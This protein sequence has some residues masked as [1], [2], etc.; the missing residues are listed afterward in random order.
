[1]FTSYTLYHSHSPMTPFDWLL[2]Y[3]ICVSKTIML[4]CLF[5][6]TWSVDSTVHDFFMCMSRCLQDHR[7]LCLTL[8]L[9]V[10]LFQG[11]ILFM[12][13]KAVYILRSTASILYWDTEESHFEF[14]KPLFCVA[15]QYTGQ[16][17]DIILTNGKTCWRC[18]IERYWA[19][20]WFHFDQW[21]CG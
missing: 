17:C 15:D 12:C 18:D 2:K 21:E 3:I 13:I 14:Y 7:Y 16:S 19:V 10:H 4:H 8:I 11:Y 5:P 9:Q 1:M 20:T 6:K